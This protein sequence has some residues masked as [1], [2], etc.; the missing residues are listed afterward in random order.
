MPTVTTD[1]TVADVNAINALMDRAADGCDM[2]ERHRIADL[3]WKLCFL[4]RAIEQAA[5]LPA[6]PTAP[7]PGAALSSQGETQDEE[8]GQIT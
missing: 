5:K 3:M 7:D 4:G 8:K 1:L 2:P 6:S